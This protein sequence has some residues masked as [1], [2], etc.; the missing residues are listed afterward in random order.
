VAS[1]G[2]GQCGLKRA[3]KKDGIAREELK[4]VIQNRLSGGCPAAEF[5][6]A[7]DVESGAP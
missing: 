6:L 5:I 3:E 4:L 2:I 1:F 7:G